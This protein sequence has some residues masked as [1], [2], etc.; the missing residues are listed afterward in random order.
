MIVGAAFSLGLILRIMDILS[1]GLMLSMLHS[2]S[3]DSPLLHTQGG[4]KTNKR[5]YIQI[6]PWWHPNTLD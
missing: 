5:P 2:I 6:V 3:S 1:K 4:E